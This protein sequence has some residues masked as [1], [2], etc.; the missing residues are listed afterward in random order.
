MVDL[1]LSAIEE[2]LEGL[3]TTCAICLSL[4][5]RSQILLLLYQRDSS[6]QVSRQPPN[7]FSMKI[8]RWRK[9]HL[10]WLQ[11][12]DNVMRNAGGLTESEAHP[13]T[14]IP[15]ILHGWC[16]GSHH[17]DCHSSFGTSRPDCSQVHLFVYNFPCFKKSISGMLWIIHALKD[18]HSYMSIWYCWHQLWD[19]WIRYLHA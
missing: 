8:L 9:I 18:V 17:A 2:L 12:C 3:S 14:S 4:S 10:L 13:R 7:S 5:G 1:L 15:L 6:T 16:A 11:D 19:Q